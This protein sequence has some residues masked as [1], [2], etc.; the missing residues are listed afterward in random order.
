MSLIAA[1]ATSVSAYAV[2]RSRFDSGDSPTDSPSSSMPVLPGSFWSL[3]INATWSARSSS[4]RSR[5]SAWSAEVADRIRY[6]EPY[7]RL[8]SRVSAAET[9]GSSSTVR[10]VGRAMQVLPP[11][12]AQHSSRAPGLRRP[13]RA[14]SGSGVATLLLAPGHGGR[15]VDAVVVE[16]L[17][18]RVAADP[19]VLGQRGQG[20]ADDRLGVDLEVPP[21]CRPRVG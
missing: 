10:I 17:L 3:T 14:R 15:V 21:R 18:H 1:I 20:L 2:S 16:R 5:S 19:S 7:L 4:D 12:G 11:V 13:V 6:S 8:R 9:C